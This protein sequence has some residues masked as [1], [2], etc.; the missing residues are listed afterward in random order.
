MFNM[1]DKT[2]QK[3]VISFVYIT[4]YQFWRHV[5]MAECINDIAYRNVFDMHDS[6]EACCVVFQYQNNAPNIK[7]LFVVSYR[8]TM[9][10]DQTD[11]INVFFLFCMRPSFMH[12]LMLTPWQKHSMSAS[13]VSWWDQ[14]YKLREI[15]TWKTWYR[16]LKKNLFTDLFTDEGKTSL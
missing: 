11:F 7:W 6:G 16:Q 3:R 1:R 8:Y 12:T 13:F 2:I 15:K 9:R 14:N 10:V 4:L 5:L